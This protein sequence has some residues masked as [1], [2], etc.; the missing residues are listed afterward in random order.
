VTQR[1]PV[2]APVV[3]LSSNNQGQ[4]VHTHVPL[5]SSG[6]TWYR[7]KLAINRHTRWCADIYLQCNGAM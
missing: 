4:V 5:S 3:M 2:G 7:Q 6:I 1:L